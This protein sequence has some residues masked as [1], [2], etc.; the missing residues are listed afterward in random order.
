MLRDAADN[1]NDGDDVEKPRRSQRLR[2]KNRGY[3]VGACSGE[4]GGGREVSQSSNCDSENQEE[5]CSATT[6]TTSREPKCSNRSAVKK[7]T[8]INPPDV[9][10]VIRAFSA[11]GR[12]KKEVDAKFFDFLVEMNPFKQRRSHLEDARRIADFYQELELD[13]PLTHTTVTREAYTPK[14]NSEE[15]RKEAKRSHHGIAEEFR[16]CSRD[17]NRENC[18]VMFSAFGSVS[19]DLPLEQQNSANSLSGT[20]TTILASTTSPSHLM[21][22]STSVSHSTATTSPRTTNSTTISSRDGATASSFPA[23]V[24]SSSS[25]SITSLL[26]SVSPLS[27]FRASSSNSATS[28]T[29]SCVTASPTLSSVNTTIPLSGVPSS[30]DVLPVD[31]ADAAPG[32]RSSVSVPDNIRTLSPLT[33]SLGPLGMFLFNQQSLAA[34][35]DPPGA[36]HSM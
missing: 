31:A 22:T 32:G 23:H 12:P 11:P 2:K 14:D 5:N 17:N 10:Q 33:S 24:P 19:R 4:G 7:R 27:R 8:F 36:N 21:S 13:T 26:S 18:E 34:H 15:E 25:S 1:D 9:L 3:T 29:S 35:F 28:E 30:V 16:R 6:T 20:S